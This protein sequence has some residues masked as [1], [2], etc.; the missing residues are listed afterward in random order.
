MPH[1]HEA[2]GGEP[3]PSGARVHRRPG[4]A[5]STT[6]HGRPRRRT[7]ASPAGRPSSGRRGRRCRTSG[8]RRQGA[9]VE[10]V[11]GRR[12]ARRRTTGAQRERVVPVA[13]R[14]RERAGVVT[15]VISSPDV[16]RA[17]GCTP[18]TS[19]S[20]RRSACEHLTMPLNVDIGASTL[21]IGAVTS[22]VTLALISHV[23]R[24]QPHRA[25]AGVPDGDLLGGVVEHHLVAGGH[26]DPHLRPR[27]RCRR[28]P[29]GCRPGSAAAGCCWPAP[30]SCGSAALPFHAAPTT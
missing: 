23:G 21:T 5:D 9:R 1:P 12:L 26:G 29:A 8:C 16:P 15:V 18:A 24:G 30:A 2:V 11:E 20:A 27:R 13:G 7:P 19:P 10:A 3:A 25:A 4:P 22:T 14:G 6:D 17:R 28:T